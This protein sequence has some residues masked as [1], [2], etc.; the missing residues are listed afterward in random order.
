MDGLWCRILSRV[1]R[2]SKRG[3]VL[4][5]M[6]RRSSSTSAVCLEPSKHMQVPPFSVAQFVPLPTP[7]IAFACTSCRLSSQQSSSTAH[8]FF[9]ATATTEDVTRP[10]F[11][12]YVGVSR[13]ACG[14]E[15]GNIS[16]PLAVRHQDRRLHPP[17]ISDTKAPA[18]CS[19]E[20]GIQTP[21]IHRL[22]RREQIPNGHNITCTFPERKAGAFI[23]PNPLLGP[24]IRN[25]EVRFHVNLNPKATWWKKFLKDAS[26][27]ET[28]LGWQTQLPH[29]KFLRITLTNWRD[30]TCLFG[31]CPGEH[32]EQAVA[33][34]N[35]KHTLLRAHG[36][37]IR[38]DLPCTVGHKACSPRE[39][40]SEV[41]RGAVE[42]LMDRGGKDA[43]GSIQRFDLEAD[44][45]RILTSYEE[46]E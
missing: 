36:I 37:K 8:I 22:L 11:Q 14:A 30:G 10:G 4:D 18:H 25:L 38:V 45:L 28:T 35:I 12:K 3:G 40:Y 5:T 26:D 13:F 43:D 29:L 16:L 27:A 44:V 20:Q 42:E 1:P 46:L 21:G 33:W 24:Y 6:K 15:A 41:M 32:I 31:T 19:T 23:T 34:M 7:T 17:Q 39:Q 2:M 9:P